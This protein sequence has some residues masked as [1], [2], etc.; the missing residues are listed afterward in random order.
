MQP[1][2]GTGARNRLIFERLNRKDCSA[3][4][5]G[6]ELD[7]SRQRVSEIFLKEKAKSE[8]PRNALAPL[9]IHCRRLL[10]RVLRMDSPT[11]PDLKRF[12][13]GNSD[14]EERL[15]FTPRC[16]EQKL[17]QIKS[18]MRENGVI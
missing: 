4:A 5:I 3:A 11:I 15:F 12:V 14:W 10:Q 6:R 17:G 13:D 7:I 16:G 2:R 18:F 9:D 8:R 1:E